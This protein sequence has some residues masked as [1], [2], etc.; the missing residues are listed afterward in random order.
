MKA[1]EEQMKIAAKWGERLS[2][3]IDEAEQNDID[4]RL[5][6]AI[7]RDAQ[8]QVNETIAEQIAK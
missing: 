5:I 7:L 2:R 1:T 3:L 6:R 4:F 8:D